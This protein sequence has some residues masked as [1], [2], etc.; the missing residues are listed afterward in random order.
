MEQDSDLHSKV[1]EALQK[2]RQSLCIRK[3]FNRFSSH[4]VPTDTPP[5]RRHRFGS[6]QQY[7]TGTGVLALLRQTSLCPELISSTEVLICFERVVGERNAQPPA[8]QLPGIN[9]REFTDLLAVVCINTMI[10]KCGHLEQPDA[11]IDTDAAVATFVQQFMLAW[12]ILKGQTNNEESHPSPVRSAS[13]H[14]PEKVARSPPVPTTPASSQSSQASS[15]LSFV[16]RNARERK[17][18]PTPVRS[19]I[20][21]PRPQGESVVQ[22]NGEGPTENKRMTKAV[23]KEKKKMKDG[24]FNLFLVRTA[25]LEAKRQR[26][27]NRL[28]SEVEKGWFKSKRVGK[29]EAEETGQRLAQ[30]RKKFFEKNKAKHHKMMHSDTKTGQRFFSPIVNRREPKSK[31]CLYAN[32]LKKRQRHK[33]NAY[34]K[35]QEIKRQ[36]E[37]SKMNPQSEQY[38]SKV[39][40]EQLFSHLTLN[41]SGDLLSRENFI[42]QLGALGADAKLRRALEQVCFEKE[43]KYIHIDKV[44]TLAAQAIESSSLGIETDNAKLATKRSLAQWRLGRVFRRYHT[45]NGCPGRRKATTA[46]PKF[47]FK[48]TISEKS[49]KLDAKKHG[50]ILSFDQRLDELSK[51]IL[52]P[53]NVESKEEDLEEC[54]FKP[55]INTSKV[56]HEQRDVVRRL[57]QTRSAETET[58]E[59]STSSIEKERDFVHNP[60]SAEDRLSDFQK[61]E[62]K[63]PKS[64]LETVRR[65][66]EAKHAADMLTK[67]KPMPRVKRNPRTGHVAVT[68]FRFSRSKGHRG[69]AALGSSNKK[70]PDFSVPESDSALILDNLLFVCKVQIAEKPLP[71]TKRIAVYKNDVPSRLASRFAALYDLNAQ[72]EDQLCCQLK[73]LIHEYYCLDDERV[74][75]TQRLNVASALVR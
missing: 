39:L 19:Q 22:S 38:A 73:N 62:P 11:S 71:I 47:S 37:A 61:L 12:E 59:D 32:A 44:E 67:E 72:A 30:S 46:A 7:L 56:V 2:T 25:F 14:T 53:E 31:E 70:M 36:Q 17:A 55:N 20:V 23:G 63:Y 28:R 24:N 51:P 21:L 65:I 16:L 27:I 49:R 48:P 3:L 29:K 4:S 43:T 68:P 45:I 75:N 50:V 18:E 6:S 52:R 66:R 60:K 74:E 57:S 58:K 26:N 10:A 64:Y 54:T 1:V 8:P 13:R 9:F 69:N 33:L 40:K 34:A 42:K 41:S 5:H 15:H 35:T